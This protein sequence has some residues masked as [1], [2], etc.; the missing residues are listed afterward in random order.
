MRRLELL[1][2]AVALAL[3]VPAAATGAIGFYF[4]TAAAT[5]EVQ[6]PLFVPLNVYVL[7][8]EAP[9]AA[10]D[11]ARF[12]YRLDEVGW[13]TGV[14]YRVAE[15]LYGATATTGGD[16]LDGWYDLAW[17]VPRPA[18]DVLPLLSW[19]LM[20]VSPAQKALYLEGLEPA[21]QPTVTSAGASQPVAVHGACGI[22]VPSWPSAI[23]NFYCPLPVEGQSWGAIKALFR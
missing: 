1:F 20:F 5:T 21:G 15:S 7:L 13:D 18:G 10:V 22:Q 9:F 8:T 17:A 12:A 4:D 11:G 2:L 6:C 16:A 19:T 14:M 23:I 3:P